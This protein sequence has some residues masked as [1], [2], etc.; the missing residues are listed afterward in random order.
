MK[1]YNTVLLISFLEWGM[2]QIQVVKKM[3]THILSSLTFFPKI[4]PFLK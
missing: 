3:K 1:I 2:L 4:M